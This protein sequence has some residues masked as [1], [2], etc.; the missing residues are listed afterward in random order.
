MVETGA[1]FF[2]AIDADRRGMTAFR[3]GIVD[4]HNWLAAAINA[5]GGPGSAF[6][7][8]YQRL[9][10]RSQRRVPLL[11]RVRSHWTRRDRACALTIR[12]RLLA[13]RMVSGA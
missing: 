8:P 5:E 13:G 2:F 6:A 12:D 11:R 4:L 1:Y 9:P 10:M 7:I 3:S